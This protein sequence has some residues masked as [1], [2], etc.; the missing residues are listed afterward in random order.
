[1]RASQKDDLRLYGVAALAFIA[2]TTITVA[3]CKP[4][5]AMPGMKMPG[6]WTMTMMWMRAPGQT[7]LEAGG[8]FLAMWTVMM[9]AMMLPVFAPALRRIRRE[10]R[11]SGAV[12]AIGFAVGYFGVWSA[13]GLVLFP[14]GVG[15][16]AL[17]MRSEMLS[18]VTPL[19]GG[20]VAM[21]AGTLQFTSWKTRALVCCRLEEDCCG[22]QWLMPRDGLRAGARLGLKCAYCCAGLTAFL[23]V[24]GVMDLVVMALVAIAITAERLT[25][26]VNVARMVGAGMLICGI[27]LVGRAILI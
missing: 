17:A 4:M 27:V 25:N 21:I 15:F 23:L 12:P 8:T 11:R 13:V 9:A 22:S 20:L 6:G 3:W 1:L 26:A 5:S 7:W 24:T 19:L 14:V 18:K 2:S 16:N 10:A